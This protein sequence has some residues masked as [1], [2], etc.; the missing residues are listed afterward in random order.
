M[1]IF[2]SSS[3]VLIEL[4]TQVLHKGRYD[5]ESSPYS[6]FDCNMKS[7]FQRHP[8]LSSC[9]MLPSFRY[10]STILIFCALPKI[11]DLICVE[12]WLRAIRHD[13]YS[14]K[15]DGSQICLFLIQFEVF[16]RREGFLTGHIRKTW[17]TKTA[18]LITHFLISHYCI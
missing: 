5:R 3:L 13:F 6:E 18:K 4:Y 2:H 11:Y 8:I 14:E 15:N 17:V 12:T 7:L 10:L 9:I 1:T 16:A